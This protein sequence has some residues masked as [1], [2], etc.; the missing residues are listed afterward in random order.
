MEKGFNK[1]EVLESLFSGEWVNSDD[2]QKALYLD[3]SSCF[4]LFEFSRT[5]EWLS[6]VGETP[7]ERAREGQKIVTKFRIKKLVE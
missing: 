5:A 7:E 6:I 4:K 1:I 3:F 2:V